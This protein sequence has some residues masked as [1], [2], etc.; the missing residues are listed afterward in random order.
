MRKKHIKIREV[1]N[2]P[3]VFSKEEENIESRINEFFNNSNRIT[4]EIGCGHGDYSSCMA[5]LH[6]ERNFVGVDIKSA[7]IWTASLKASA[8]ELKNVAFLI[9]NAELL[10]DFFVNNKIEEIWIPFPD[11]HPRRKS[12]FKRLVSPT[13]LGTYN[14]LLI[15]GA[16][17]NLKTDDDNF[18]NFA[19]ETVSTPEYI[20]HKSYKNLH[21]VEELTPEEQIQT[22]YEKDHLMKGRTI[23]F[24]SF[25]FK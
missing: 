22:K 24:L 15:S 10:P 3:N 14:K 12:S 1:R 4:L 20:I 5:E 23:K 8:K 6:P 13:L 25:S 11:T 17:I 9:S 7:R 16:K 2:L 21:E 18:Y 19:L